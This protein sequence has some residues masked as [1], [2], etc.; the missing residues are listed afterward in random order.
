MRQTKERILKMLID[1]SCERK[2]ENRN[3]KINKKYKMV[4]FFG[5]FRFMCISCVRNILL[6]KRKATRKLKSLLNQLSKIDTDN[7]TE[8]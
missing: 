7:E 8:R 3:K 5:A 1:E 6:E 2:V 4:K